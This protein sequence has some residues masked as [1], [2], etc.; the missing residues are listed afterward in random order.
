MT[1][2][3]RVTLE[4]LPEEIRKRIVYIEGGEEK[5]RI[6]M[7][8]PNPGMCND[9]PEVAL[10]DPEKLS[11]FWNVTCNIWVKGHLEAYLAERAELEERARQ[12]A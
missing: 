12:G 1:V 2:S 4:E 8:R 5:A 9:S 7:S 11:H 3:G 6:W 10:A